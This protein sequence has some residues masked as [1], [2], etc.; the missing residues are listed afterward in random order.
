MPVPILQS[1]PVFS[2]SLASSRPL[3]FPPSPDTGPRTAQHDNRSLRQ[4]E[5]VAQPNLPRLEQPALVPREL[6]HPRRA[7]SAQRTQSR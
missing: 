2:A 3:R 1:S 6:V 7:P 4:S 5:S